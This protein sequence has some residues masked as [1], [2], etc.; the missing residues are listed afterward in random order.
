MPGRDV[1]DVKGDPELAYQAASWYGSVYTVNS[2]ARNGPFSKEP[3]L[4]W[5]ALNAIDRAATAR[6]WVAASARR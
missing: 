4:R 6:G 1:P 5:A 2:S 3:A